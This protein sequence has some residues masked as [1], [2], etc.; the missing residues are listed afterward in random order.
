MIAVLIAMVLLP[1]DQT[2]DILP[3]ELEPVAFL[4]LDEFDDDRKLWFLY[5]YSLMTAI[6]KGKFSPRPKVYLVVS[7]EPNSRSQVVS[8]TSGFWV[9]QKNSVP[10]PGRTRGQSVGLHTVCSPNLDMIKVLIPY[11]FCWRSVNLKFLMLS[12]IT[13]RVTHF[14]FSQLWS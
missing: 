11:H 10:L 3:L 5:A 8:R 1:Y 2:I 6:L 14:I 9:F 13:W 12:C 4:W 7:K